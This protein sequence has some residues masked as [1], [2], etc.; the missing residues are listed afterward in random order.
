MHE[1]DS[2]DNERA[3]LITTSIRLDLFYENADF[4]VDRGVIDMPDGTKADRITFIA[5]EKRPNIMKVGIR[6][7]TEEI[8]AMQTNLAFPI[9]N[10]LPMEFDFTLRLGKRIKAEANL[11]FHP[12]SLITPNIKLAFHRNNYYIYRKGSIF[13]QYRL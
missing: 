13:R 1:G 9:R 7:D 2:I 12:T 11:D 10:K 6:F 4:H 8:V 5:G 3:H